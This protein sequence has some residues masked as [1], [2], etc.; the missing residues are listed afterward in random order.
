MFQIMLNCFVSAPATVLMVF[1]AFLFLLDDAQA[2]NYVRRLAYLART[3]ALPG[4]RARLPLGD[5]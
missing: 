5:D 1:G 3:G 4:G 2:A